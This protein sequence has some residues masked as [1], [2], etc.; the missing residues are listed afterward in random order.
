MKKQIFVEVEKFRKDNAFFNMEYR[1][2]NEII[3]RYDEI[4]TNKASKISLRE[5]KAKIEAFIESKIT[6]IKFL[7]ES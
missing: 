3:I 2:Y 5:L 1:K 7:F 4:I 6:N